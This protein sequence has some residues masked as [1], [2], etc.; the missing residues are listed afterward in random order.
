MPGAFLQ[1][2]VA[3]DGTLYA[4]GAGDQVRGFYRSRDG[5]R[6]WVASDTGLFGDEVPGGSP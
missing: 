3:R 2:A 5:G 4:H 1:L 6:T